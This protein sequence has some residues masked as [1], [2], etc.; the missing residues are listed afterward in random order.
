MLGNVTAL[1]GE[2]QC[3]GACSLGFSNRL[4]CESGDSR[5][6]DFF[7]DNLLVRIRFIIVMTQWTGLAPWKFRFSFTCG[8]TSAFLERIMV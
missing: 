5:E 3:C 8:L 1:G 2:L 7:I 6:I 4:W